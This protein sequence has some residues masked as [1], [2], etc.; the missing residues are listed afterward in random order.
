MTFIDLYTEPRNVYIDLEGRSLHEKTPRDMVTQSKGTKT[1]K[2][3]SKMRALFWDH[4]FTKLRWNGDSAL[5]AR[6]ILTDGDWDSIRWL[7]RQAGDE[8][9][10]DWIETHHRA[11]SPRQL[12]FWELIL[13]LPHRKVNEWVAAAHTSVWENRHDPRIWENRLQPLGKPQLSKAS[14]KGQRR[15]A[16]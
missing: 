3:P 12:R 8:A 6:R 14:I 9:M 13:D 15:K 11:L 16:R 1:T 5:I 4:D 7:R 2:L 10:R